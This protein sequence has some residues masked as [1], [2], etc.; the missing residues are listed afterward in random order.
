MM[1]APKQFDAVNRD[2]EIRDLYNSEDAFGLADGY[3]AAY[4]ARLNANLAF[5][6]GLDGNVDWPLEE[7]GSHPLTELVLADYL[8]V[9]ATKPY[10]ERGS[11]LEI[12]LAA[13]R[14]EAHRTCGG[15]TLNDDVIDTM[16]TQLI[17][18]GNGPVIRDGVD[19]S[20]RPATR[21]FPYLAEPNPDPPDLPEHH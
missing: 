6:D 7:G 4:R 5:W 19:R 1:L 11:Y 3:L 10:V 16:F 8:V 14:G 13:L 2:L 20:S 21:T 9:D 18:A 17:N 15:R 12:E